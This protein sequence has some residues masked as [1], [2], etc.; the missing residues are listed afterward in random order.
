[1]GEGGGEGMNGNCFTVGR[2]TILLTAVTPPCLYLV[3][4]PI[5]GPNICGYCHYSMT[6][7]RLDRG[8]RSLAHCDGSPV[9]SGT[10]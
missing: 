2:A 4:T 5:L 9:E 7:R 6:N 10:V 1:M 3:V 8:Y